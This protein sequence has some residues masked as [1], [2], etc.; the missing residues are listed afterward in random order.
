MATAVA[1][2]V[3]ALAVVA[4]YAHRGVACGHDL[5]FHMNSW[6]EAQQ[7]WHEGVLYPR[8]APN[9]NFGSG[10]P[11]FIFY[12]PLSWM[13][14]AAL[15]SLLP[16][17]FVPAAFEFCT[18]VFAGWAMYRLA[19]E[20]FE[21][22][23]A[24]LMAVAYAVNPYALLTYYARSAC[25]EMVA[26]GFVPLI[27]WIVVREAKTYSF[28][29][30]SRADARPGSQSFPSGMVVPLA[31]TIAGV[32][33]ANVP[34]A[35]PATYL[36]ALLL[37]IVAVM[38]GSLRVL[39]VG[40][41]GIALGLALA[42]VYIVPVLR[43]HLWINMNQL[44][45]DNANPHG[46][47][48]FLGNGDAGHDAFLRVVSWLAVGLTTVTAVAMAFASRVRREKPALW[49]SLAISTAVAFVLMLPVS[50]IFYRIV[51]ELKTMQFPW[52]WLLVVGTAYAVFI[53]SA[54]PA[55]RFKPWLYAVAFVVLIVASN[56]A[57][58]PRCDPAETPSMV[59]SL[60]HTGYGYM[61][62]DE[63]TPLGGDNYEI[64]PDFPE[65]RVTPADARVADWHASTYRKQLTVESAQ[66][67]QLVL[68]LMNYPPW[69]VTV[70]GSVVEA[71]SEDPTGRM[72]VALPAG[73]SEV[74]VRYV[75]TADRWVG[76]GI[77]V[78]AAVLCVVLI[79]RNNRRRRT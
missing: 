71:Q 35:I 10:E 5:V 42:A 47:L 37:A 49:W 41:C 74:E 72:V 36:T 16:W 1:L 62:T 64:K 13:L 30:D 26:A 28:A 43:E 46:N 70:N 44:L 54:V 65:Y 75:R 31:L 20:W 59:A 25:G 34:A 33:L 52:R 73:R 45:A 22:S 21:P 58:Q 11:R 40:G 19:R 32:W 15:A 61:G 55:F 17:I 77:S 51:P 56:R 78:V 69:R 29:N 76:D 63:Y 53:V 39:L 4:P 50:D 48:L 18:V 57:F 24:G 23:D 12:P 3:A 14:G 66:P 7:Q 2:L 79:C 68:R 6:M 9:A 67:V 8:W 27:V 60:Y 38:R